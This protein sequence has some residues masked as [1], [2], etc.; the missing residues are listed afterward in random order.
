MRELVLLARKSGFGLAD[1]ANAP[2]GVYLAV[3]EMVE[4]DIK[5]EKQN[6]LKNKLRKRK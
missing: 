3:R 2:G 6:R 5:R 1:L 4:E